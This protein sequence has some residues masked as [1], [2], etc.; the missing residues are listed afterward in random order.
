MIRLSSKET[1]PLL[2]FISACTNSGNM[3]NNIC[4]DL[5]L[6]D[7]S[8]LELIEGKNLSAFSKVGDTP[9]TSKIFGNADLSKD[10]EHYWCHY[11]SENIGEEYNSV[12]L[13]YEQS[14]AIENTPKTPTYQ[15]VLRRSLRTKKGVSTLLEETKFQ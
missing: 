8:T 6:L 3:A 7:K 2:L 4:S 14:I 13:V 15:L 9:Y 5:T 11:T 10:E 1:I 12:E